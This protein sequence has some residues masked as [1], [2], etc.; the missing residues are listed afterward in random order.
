MSRRAEND[1]VGEKILSLKFH[2]QNP[3]IVT[4]IEFTPF[5][6]LTQK[7]RFRGFPCIYMGHARAYDNLFLAA[8]CF[9]FFKG[10]LK[11]SFIELFVTVRA[12]FGW[13][14]IWLIWT[15]IKLP[16]VK[17]GKMYIWSLHFY[18]YLSGLSTFIFSNQESPHLNLATMRLVLVGTPIY[19]TTEGLRSDIC[20]RS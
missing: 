15:G 19:T 10:F 11:I 6:L 17:L 12:I 5:P 8:R 13:I 20:L 4:K 14:I 1:A 18:L 16:L 9:P 3:R 7:L 2:G